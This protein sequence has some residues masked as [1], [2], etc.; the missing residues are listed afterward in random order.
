MRPRVDMD[1]NSRRA[2]GGAPRAVATRPECVA[3]NYDS[4]YAGV[5]H[6]Y[7]ATAEVSCASG[8]LTHCA[9]AFSQRVA[10]RAR[11][12]LWA[13]PRN[14]GKSGKSIFRLDARGLEVRYIVKHPTHLTCIA[15]TQAHDSHCASKRA[16]ACGGRQRTVGLLCLHATRSSE[17]RPRKPAIDR[18]TQPREGQHDVGQ[19][20]RRVQARH[21][22]RSTGVSAAAVASM[23]S[24]SNT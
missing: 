3:Q 9:R 18:R 11:G 21:S 15:G 1:E 12:C 17:S 7:G 13:A 14:F 5:A 24:G 4:G 20:V 2:S 10:R 22:T 6:P 23:W 16:T 8:V 19:S